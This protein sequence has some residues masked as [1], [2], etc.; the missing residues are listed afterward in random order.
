[1]AVQKTTTASIN[2]AL[3]L[4]QEMVLLRVTIVSI[5]HQMFPGGDLDHIFAAGE[6]NCVVNRSS[7]MFNKF[8]RLLPLSRHSGCFARIRS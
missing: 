8:Y 2:N 3:F 7:Q 6:H 5:R 4:S 1:M